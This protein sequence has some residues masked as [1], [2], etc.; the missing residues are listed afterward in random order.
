[1]STHHTTHGGG[2]MFLDE[3]VLDHI[4]VKDL[5]KMLAETGQTVSLTK[6]QVLFLHGLKGSSGRKKH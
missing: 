4:K 1:M 5:T 2:S 6:V 3:R